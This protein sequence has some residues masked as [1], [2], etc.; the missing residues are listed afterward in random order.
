M[1]MDPVDMETSPGKAHPETVGQRI[2]ARI[3]AGQARNKARS[4]MREVAQNHPIALL[5]GGIVLG[6]IL[7]RFLPRTPFG[8]LGRGAGALAA[9]SV[10]MASRYGSR[11][12]DAASGAVREGKERLEDIGETVSETAGDA[13]RRTVDLADI[14][15]AT[16]KAITADALR[17][18][19]EAADRVRH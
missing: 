17:R 8:K 1:E 15:M 7:A 18:V 3:S 14:A 11:A 4:A 9:A 6:A 16:A 19:S 10:E 2:A 5:A 12:A 13:R